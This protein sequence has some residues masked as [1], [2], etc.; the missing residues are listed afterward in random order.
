MVRAKSDQFGLVLCVMERV[1]NAL[2]LGVQALS[3]PAGFRRIPSTRRRVHHRSLVTDL[4]EDLM[5]AVL[6]G[7]LRLDACGPKLGRHREP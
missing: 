7:I 2:D 6:S 1:V 4:A 5:I 3:H